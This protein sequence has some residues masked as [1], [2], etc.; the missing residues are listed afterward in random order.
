VGVFIFLLGASMPL[1]ESLV[2]PR[3]TP[4]TTH[5]QVFEL[6]HS[7]TLQAE[8][9]EIPPML[10]GF[11]EHGGEVL[12][13]RALYP[14][15]FPPGEG[16]PTTKFT[17]FKARP[18]SHIS[19]ILVGPRNAAVQLPAQEQLGLDFPHAADVLVFGCQREMYFE[20]LAV[21]V[22]PSQQLLLR[23]PL[24]ESPGCPFP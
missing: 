4:Q 15:Y 11:L 18:F 17:V 7:E 12:Q 10:Q 13:G 14:R 5:T 1:A 3:Y 8:N 19:F 6:L 24:P 2:R 20:A 23:A 21:F 16:E 9:P 22:E